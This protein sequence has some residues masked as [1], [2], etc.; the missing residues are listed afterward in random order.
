MTIEKMHWLLDTLC[1]QGLEIDELKKKNRELEEVVGHLRNMVDNSEK[2]IAS[3]RKKL[4]R[5]HD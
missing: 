1:T 5:N 2:A 4:E 3:L